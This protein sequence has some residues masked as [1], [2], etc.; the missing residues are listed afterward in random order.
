M[1]KKLLWSILTIFI[2]INIYTVSFATERTTNNNYN[3]MMPE[4][5]SVTSENTILLS[6][7]S[8]VGSNINIYVY[9]RRYSSSINKCVKTPVFTKELIVGELERFNVELELPIGRN[10]II[11]KINNNDQNYTLTKTINVTNDYIAKKYIENLNVLESKNTNKIL[12]AIARR[13]RK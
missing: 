2:S 12:K 13:N 7:K 11:T 4:D 6:G 3:L 10:K 5:N 1:G 8:K 9:N